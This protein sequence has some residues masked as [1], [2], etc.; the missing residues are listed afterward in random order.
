[1]NFNG[2]HTIH[3]DPGITPSD[4]LKLGSQQPGKPSAEAVAK[5]RGASFNRWPI[6]KIIARGYGVATAWYGDIEPD[7][8][9][10]LRYGVRK[11]YLKDGQSEPA[12]DEWGAIAA[13]AWG[14]SRIMDYL[15]TDPDIDARHVALIGHSRLGKTALWAGAQDE[16]F[17]LVI[18]NDSGCGGASL[19]RRQFGETPARIT[20][21]FPHWFCKN[22]RKYAFHVNDLPVDQHMLLALVAPRPLYVASAEEDRWADPH[23]EFLSAKGADPVY[24]LL[25]T[26]GLPGRR[27]ARRRTAGRGRD[28]LSHPPRQ[29]R[30]DRL[31]LAAVHGLA[32]RNFK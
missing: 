1:M 8:A 15:E 6:E 25:G 9:G 31:R 21:S 18:S 14:L 27:H 23:G 19:A 29:A 12:D 32:D 4:V 22:Y 13:W 24:R 17:A 7:M 20:T 26:A 10:G 5:A 3:A 30:R 11:L 2:N 16:R 28:F